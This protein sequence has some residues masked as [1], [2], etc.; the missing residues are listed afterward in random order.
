MP[1]QVIKI[2]DR[3]IYDKTTDDI[4]PRLEETKRRLDAKME[5]VSLDASPAKFMEAQVL[6]NQQSAQI[7]A[8]SNI[9]KSV[10]DMNETIG[11]NI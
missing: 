7:T 8:I 1:E 3:S 6:I 4:L 9:L 2:P 10:K 11:R 5:E